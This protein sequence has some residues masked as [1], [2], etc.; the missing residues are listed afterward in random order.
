MIRVVLVDDEPQSCKSLAIKLKAVADYIEITGIY[1][2]PERAVS[3]IPKI[4]PDVVFLDIE[5]DGYSRL[6]SFK[7]KVTRSVQ[8]LQFSMHD[9]VAMC[10]VLKCYFTQ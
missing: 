5:I 1:H 4:K 10:L 8:S 7:I 6:K 9:T 2:H 3:G